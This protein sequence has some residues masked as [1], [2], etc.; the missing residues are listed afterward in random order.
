MKKPKFI[1]IRYSISAPKGFSITEMA[2]NDI[3]RSIRV[4]RVFS[5]GFADN[6]FARKQGTP[7]PCVKRA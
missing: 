7:K 3:K 2:E 6:I 5:P 4:K 1:S